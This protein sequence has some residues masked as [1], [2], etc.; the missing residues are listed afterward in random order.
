[1]ISV[2]VSVTTAMMQVWVVQVPV[3][4]G[5][6]P[7]PMGMRL[8]RRGQIKVACSGLSA[9]SPGSMIALGRTVEARRTAPTISR[10]TS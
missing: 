10:S 3:Q 7:I 9:S 8:T 5:R 2:G 6:V 1:M 4:Q